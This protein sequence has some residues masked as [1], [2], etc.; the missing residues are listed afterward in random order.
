MNHVFHPEAA[1]EFEEAVRFYQP[2]GRILGGRF[3][4]EVRTAIRRI[5][6]TPDRWRILEDDVRCCVVRV[7]PYGVLYTVELE[8]ILIIAIMHS[9]REPGYWRHR[10]AS[11]PR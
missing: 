7:F 8:Y 11:K 4:S 1:Q 3:S 2:R 5:L 10:L 9:K 6:D